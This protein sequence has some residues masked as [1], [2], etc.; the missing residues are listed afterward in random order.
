MRSRLTKL[1]IAVGLIMSLSIPVGA[2]EL[3]AAHQDTP[4]NGTEV[5][6]VLHFVNNQTG[7]QGDI[8]L[9]V[10]TNQGENLGP[11]HPDK[12]NRNVNHWW[13]TVSD[14][15][16]KGN[17]LV[18][19]WTNVGEDELTSTTSTGDGKLVLSSYKCAKKS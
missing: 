1:A 11:L 12:S 6:R 18:T 2:A 14:D 13:V 8:H 17:L 15:D 10:S 9:W 19:A 16:L 7:G 4:C 5:L 3:H